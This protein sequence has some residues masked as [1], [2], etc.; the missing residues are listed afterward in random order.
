MNSQTITL[1]S[2]SGWLLSYTPCHSTLFLPSIV[3]CGFVVL[4]IAA[5]GLAQTI[6][7]IYVLS[8]TIIILECILFYS[9]A[10]TGAQILGLV[11]CRRF[12]RSESRHVF[13]MYAAFFH[14]KLLIDSISSTMAGVGSQI[15]GRRQ[16]RRPESVVLEVCNSSPYLRRG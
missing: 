16:S 3:C 14:N 7:L 15:F 2:Q 6:L 1:I 9:I 10:H 12:L 8:Q 4:S 13:F 11:L 5:S